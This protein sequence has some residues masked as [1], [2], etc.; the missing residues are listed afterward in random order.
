M[1]RRGEIIPFRSD[2]SRFSRGTILVNSLSRIPSSLANN[3]LTETRPFIGFLQILAQ[4]RKVQVGFP[5]SLDDV[6]RDGLHLTVKQNGVKYH[7]KVEAD[8]GYS[9][10]LS[11]QPLLIHVG[12]PISPARTE[13]SSAFV[14]RSSVAPTGFKSVNRDLS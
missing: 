1:N 3:P 13:R 7:F 2:I 9:L 8:G 5:G 4:S 10:L 12:A 11:E 6:K 14:K